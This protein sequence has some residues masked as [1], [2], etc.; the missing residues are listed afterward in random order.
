MPVLADVCDCAVE[1]VDLAR[2]GDCVARG[3][4]HEVAEAVVVEVAGRGDREP[5]FDAGG[6]SR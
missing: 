5:G 1:Q 4:D 3:A 2:A 6:E